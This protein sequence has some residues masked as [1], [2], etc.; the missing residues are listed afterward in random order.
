MEISKEQS[1]WIAT[2]LLK[3]QRANKSRE[4]VKRIKGQCYK[5]RWPQILHTR[6][7]QPLRQNPFKSHGENI[8]C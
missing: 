2:H 7:L 3:Q 1:Q 4:E 8:F 6:D 5:P